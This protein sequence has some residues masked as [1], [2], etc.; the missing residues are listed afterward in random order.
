MSTTK[1]PS[2]LNVAQLNQCIPCDR[3]RPPIRGQTCRHP[4]PR[5]E[6][7]PLWTRRGRVEHGASQRSTPTRASTKSSMFMLVF[8]GSKTSRAQF[9][10]HAKLSARETSWSKAAWA[11]SSSARPQSTPSPLSSFR[12]ASRRR[13]RQEEGTCGLNFL[14][15]ECVMSGRPSQSEARWSV[16]D[17][18]NCPFDFKLRS[19]SGA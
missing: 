3:A 9:G 11:L 19:G 4:P 2:S 5:L 12:Q 8:E 1:M 18:L 16:R 14:G 13:D 15:G 7:I 10:P 17:A 6:E